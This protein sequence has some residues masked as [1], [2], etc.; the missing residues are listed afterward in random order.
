MNFEIAYSQLLLPIAVYIMIIYINITRITIQVSFL[1]IFLQWNVEHLRQT[2]LRSVCFVPLSF[3]YGNYNLFYS[4]DKK[5]FHTKLLL[6]S[7]I[8]LSPGGF[9]IS[10]W[11][12]WSQNPS[13]QLLTEIL[14]S[15]AEHRGGSAVRK[16]LH[17]VESTDSLKWKLSKGPRLYQARTRLR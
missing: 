16:L 17:W 4:L 14:L 13:G 8:F 7:N 3:F 15:N 5:Y 11:S 9:Q 10:A 12:K 2:T 6:C 1:Y